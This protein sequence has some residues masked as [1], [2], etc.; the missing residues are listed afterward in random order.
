MD[1]FYNYA[2]YKERL[3]QIDNT[4]VYNE[5]AC[6]IMRSYNIPIFDISMIVLGRYSDI[7]TRGSYDGLH[8]STSLNL[9]IVRILLSVL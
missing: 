8:P 9:E 5:I 2:R 6:R 1:V 7:N 3:L 4:L